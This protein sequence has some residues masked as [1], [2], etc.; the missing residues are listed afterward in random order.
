[1]RR[2]FS[3]VT[4]ILT[5]C[6]LSPFTE[7][8]EKKAKAPQL[9]KLESDELA[10]DSRS[11]D[12]QILGIGRKLQDV[13]NRYKLMS[14]KDIKIV[15]YRVT[16]VIGD[17]YIEIS[18]YEYKRNTFVDD[19]IL[20]VKEKKL[21]IYVSGETIT[22]MESVITD[23]DIGKAGGE[24]VIIIDPSPATEGTDDILFT[25]KIHNKV[26]IDNKKLGDV[27][28]NRA[29]PVRNSIKREFLVP[30][31]S[32]AYDTILKIAELYYGAL[33]DVDDSM[34]EFLK[35]TTNY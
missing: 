15:P 12:D 13:I 22:K 10:T 1:M 21:R 7:A 2:F 32:Y 17:N 6:I 3:T 28:N 5:V 16:Y 18:Q 14:T 27:K 8:Q 29:F 31:Y 23:R 19:K 35:R 33:K 20:G 26:L 24:V 30:H 11:L 34:S 4:I 9:T 25:H